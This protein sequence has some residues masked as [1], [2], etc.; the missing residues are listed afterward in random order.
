MNF[1]RWVW[2]RCNQHGVYILLQESCFVVFHP[3][4][5]L[6]TQLTLVSSH[7]YHEQPTYM[8]IHPRKLT[9]KCHH[10]LQTANHHLL[11]L[12]FRLSILTIYRN[13]HTYIYIYKYYKHLGIIPYYP[14]PDDFL[15]IPPGKDRWLA[16]LVSLGLSWPL[17][18]KKK[19]P[20]G[21]AEKAI[22]PFTTVYPLTASFQ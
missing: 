9:E 20:F 17:T 4:E 19:P 2:F 21:S 6:I 1:K 3:E 13:K 18:L 8:Y 10:G 15:F 11:F 7:H 22:D 12:L 14:I 16:T 5:N